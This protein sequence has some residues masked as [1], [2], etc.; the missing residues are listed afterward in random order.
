M[1]VHTYVCM[2]VHFFLQNVIIYSYIHIHIAICINI[3][4][5]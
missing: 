5:L 4:E 1:Y 3:V 2:H